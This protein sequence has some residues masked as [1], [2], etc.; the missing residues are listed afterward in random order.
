VANDLAQ[1][2]EVADDHPDVVARLMQL[3]AA[4]RQE[5]GDIDQPGRGER[6]AGKVTNPVPLLAS[7]PQP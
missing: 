5:I 3:A 7:P 6:A 4:I 2:D 1:A